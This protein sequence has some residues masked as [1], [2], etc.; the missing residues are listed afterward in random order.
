MDVIQKKVAPVGVGKKWLART[1]SVALLGSVVLPIVVESNGA[2]AATK[3]SA[4]RVAKKA[5]VKKAPVK[6]APVKK[7]PV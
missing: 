1:L 3:A 5:P 2:L 7:A 6:K 4:Q